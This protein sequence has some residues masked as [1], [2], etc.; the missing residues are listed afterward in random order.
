M[1]VKVTAVAHRVLWGKFGGTCEFFDELQNQYEVEAI[2][3]GGPEEGDR[4]VHVSIGLVG[5]C[6]QV[7]RDTRNPGGI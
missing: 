5:F 7:H 6:S 2:W 1:S 3:K 4:P